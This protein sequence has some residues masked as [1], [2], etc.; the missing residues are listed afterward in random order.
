MQLADEGS[1]SV[2]ILYEGVVGTCDFHLTVN[3][4]TVNIIDIDGESPRV[5]REGDCQTMSVSKYC[6]PFSFY[7]VSNKRVLKCGFWVI[8]KIRQCF[9]WRLLTLIT[10]YHLMTLCGLKVT[11]F[12]INLSTLPTLDSPRRTEAKQSR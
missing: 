2:E 10:I 5:V 1:Y 12:W 11:V 4:F 9:R 6:L 7:T 8:L 3:Q